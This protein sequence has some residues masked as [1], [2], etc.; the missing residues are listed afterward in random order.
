VEKGHQDES[1]AIFKNGAAFLACQPLERIAEIVEAFAT[2]C[3][4]EASN[5]LGRSIYKGNC[6]GSQKVVFLNQSLP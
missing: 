2:E 1:N 5:E 3:T 4:W 6:R